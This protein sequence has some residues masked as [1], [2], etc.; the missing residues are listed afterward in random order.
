MEICRAVSSL[1][2]AVYLKKGVKKER[3]YHAHRNPIFLKRNAAALILSQ[4]RRMASFW[5]QNISCHN[6]GFFYFRRAG[7]YLSFQ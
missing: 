4:N 1:I 2:A 3:T 6:C 5:P 7:L